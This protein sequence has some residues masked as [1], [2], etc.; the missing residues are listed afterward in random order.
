MSKNSEDK[1]LKYIVITILAMISFIG[2]FA[3]SAFFLNADF[4]YNLKKCSEMNS[5]TSNYDFTHRVEIDARYNEKCFYYENYPYARL[6]NIW[7]PALVGSL[8]FTMMISFLISLIWV[9][10]IE[11]DR[12]ESSYY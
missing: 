9:I 4:D 7:I 8:V 10:C 1:T 2:I 11:N 6:T 5:G 3:M 12:Y